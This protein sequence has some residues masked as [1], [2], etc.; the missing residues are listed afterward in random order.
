[1]RFARRFRSHF[2]FVVRFLHFRG[3]STFNVMVTGRFPGD[4][5]LIIFTTWP[6][7]RGYANVQVR[8]RIPWGLP[9]VLVIISRLKATMVVERYSSHVSSNTLYLLSWPVYRPIHSTISTA[10]DQGR[11]C[12]I[13]SSRFSVFTTVSFGEG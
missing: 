13:P 3:T 12:L 9:N 10:S 11:P 6:S 2:R 7:G 8:G 4:A 5:S 1:M